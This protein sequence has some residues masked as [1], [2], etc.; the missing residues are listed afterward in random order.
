MEQVLDQEEERRSTEGLIVFTR[1]SVFDHVRGIFTRW[2]AMFVTAL[3][4]FGVVWTLA[5]ATSYFLEVDL[6]GLGQL[7]I[8]LI[9][10][11]VSSLAWGVYAYTMDAPPGLE[12]ESVEARRIG[13]LQLPRWEARLA[14]QLLHDAIDGFDEELVALQDGRVFVPIQQDLILPEYTDWATRRLANLRR[15]MEVALR[16]LVHDFRSSLMSSYTIHKPA[17]IRSV[18]YRIC[19]F[20]SATVEFEVDRLR[21][22]PPEG[23]ERL[24]EL[25]AGWS[26]PIRQGV[27]QLFDLT[28][29]LVT[30]DLQSEKNLSF[31]V[32]LESPPNVDEYC[33][34]VDALQRRGTWR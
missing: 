11:L 20:Y 8:A 6:S 24:H 31:T 29:R 10:S 5:E 21:I 14:R 16:L 22:R 30:V 18:V 27:R 32:T 13:Q 26:E 34:E 15:M 2:R 28:D 1:K 12:H 7:L 9:F 19:E 23:G 3:A 17:D 4:V 33:A 25:Q